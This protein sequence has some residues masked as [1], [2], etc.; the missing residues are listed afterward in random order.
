MRQLIFTGN[1]VKR[2]RCLRANMKW[3]MGTLRAPSQRFS[4]C[5]ATMRPP[6]RV[7]RDCGDTAGVWWLSRRCVMH[8]VGRR[9]WSTVSDS[10]SRDPTR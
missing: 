5:G 9:P 3:I 1:G 2:W 4:R 6:E 7:R 8:Q 10:E